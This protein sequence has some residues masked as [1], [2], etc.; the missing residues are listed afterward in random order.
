MVA[1][2][3]IPLFLALFASLSGFPLASRAEGEKKAEEGKT[4]ERLVCIG[5]LSG[6]HIYTTYGYIGTVADGYAHDVYKAEKV[7]EL[8]K[9]VVGLSEVSMKQLKAVRDGN[10]VD[11][12]KK[13]IDDV[14]EVY[15]LLQKEAKALSD[16]TKSKDKDDLAKF[17]AARTAA[18]PKIK[19]VLGIKDD[20]N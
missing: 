17:E 9:E 13:V 7:Q 19:G 8:M 20:A 14:S 16:Y 5:A 4:D 18:W 12:D 2:L 15:G 1:S 6:A 11:V 3:R 10:I